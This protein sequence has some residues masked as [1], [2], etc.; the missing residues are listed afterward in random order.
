VDRERYNKEMVVYQLEKQ[1]KNREEDEMGMRMLSTTVAPLHHHY[2]AL[3]PLPHPPMKQGDTMMA[4][5]S[6]MA[7]PSYSY[8]GG[9]SSNQGQPQ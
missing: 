7:L 1:E 3:L 5:Q 4:V 2:H 6:A 8:Q 9:C